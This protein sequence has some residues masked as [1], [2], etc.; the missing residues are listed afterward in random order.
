[1]EAETTVLLERDAPRV[2]TAR[3]AEQT[4]CD[5][6]GLEPSEHYVEVPELGSRIRVVEVGDGHLPRLDEPGTCGHL[7]RDFLEGR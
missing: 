7:I 6:Y 1:M 2:R 3:S 5:H 4:A